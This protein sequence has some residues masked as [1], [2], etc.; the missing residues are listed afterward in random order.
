MYLAKV[1]VAAK[2]KVGERMGTVV[3]F[4]SEVV[5]VSLCFRP[6]QSGKISRMA[7]LEV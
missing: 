4:F 5:A 2:G 1:K 6:S 3:G 7:L